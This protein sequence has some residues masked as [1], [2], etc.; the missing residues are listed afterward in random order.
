MTI[1]NRREKEKEDLHR[2]ILS[3]AR[4]I[5]LEKGYD[6]T[7]IRNIAQKIDYSPTT[8]YLYF[9]DKDAIFHALHI[10]GFQILHNRMEPLFSVEDPFQRLI[11]MGRIYMAFAAENPD[12]YDLM[13]VQK[14][15][16]EFLDNEE[17]WKEG[18]NSFNGLMLTI[19]QCMD[20]GTLNFKDAE[21]G[22]YL[23]WSM[24]HGMIILNAKE[25]CMIISDEKQADIVELS[26]AA[27]TEML[28]QFKKP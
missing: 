5:F 26:F 8:I 4:E 3:A 11:A 16:I 23:V 22:A 6:Q 27:F 17:P 18:E 10:E 7:S 19:Q 9:K 1:S 24:M 13:F 14:A 2:S 20:N 12:F 28:N 21:I 25:R 15:P